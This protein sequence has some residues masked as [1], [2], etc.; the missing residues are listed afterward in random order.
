MPGQST[1]TVRA[2]AVLTSSRPMWVP[3]N[4]VGNKRIS[5]VRELARTMVTSSKPS[6]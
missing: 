6:A 1:V 3:L 2:R 5:F 4:T